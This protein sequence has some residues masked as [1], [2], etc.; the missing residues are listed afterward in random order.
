MANQHTSK[1]RPNRLKAIENGEKKYLNVTP[2]KKCGTF[3]MYVSNYGCVFCLTEA[4]LEKLNNEELMAPYRTRE[5]KNKYCKNNK[6]RVK[7]IKTK[8]AK[9]ERGRAV[10]AENQ[11][12]RHAR[13]KKGIPIEITEE[14]LRQM[15]QIYQEAQN[16]TSTTGIRYEVDHII[17]LFEGGMH[18][19]DNLQI[20]T[21]EE[22]I[23]KTAKENSRRLSK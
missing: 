5:K 10:A 6:E 2:C 15:Q 19:P 21:R 14:E 22:H 13:V 1:S 20:I 7:K 18:H 16:L 8:Y 12:R 23:K 17:P 4:G 11:R 9:S 3:E